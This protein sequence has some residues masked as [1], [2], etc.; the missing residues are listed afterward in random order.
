[1]QVDPSP[2]CEKL[3]QMF[4][5]DKAGQIDVREFMIGLSN[6]T[7]A[8]KEE[9]LKFA[10]MVFDEDG[11]GEIEESEFSGWIKNGLKKTKEEREIFAA[12]STLAK[13]LCQFLN[14]VEV[15]MEALL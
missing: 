10:F 2:Q 6:F 7:G 5:K 14:A 13:K 11:N 3:F 8:G 12:Q 15:L 4:D 1:M 9:K